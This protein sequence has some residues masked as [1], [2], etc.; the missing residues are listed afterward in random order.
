MITYLKKNNLVTDKI[1]HEKV[2]YLHRK[3]A[4]SYKTLKTFNLDT[5]NKMS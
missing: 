2:K 1:T 5:Y 3:K 4:D